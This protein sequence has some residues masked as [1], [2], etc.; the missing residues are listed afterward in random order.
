MRAWAAALLII[1]SGCINPGSVD[2]GVRNL[3]ETRVVD[4]G[5]AQHNRTTEEYYFVI[6]RGSE[7]EE[8]IDG[9]DNA[10][11]VTCGFSPAFDYDENAQS[12]HYDP[13]AVSLPVEEWAVV[14][15]YDYWG[16]QVED[17]SVYSGCPTLHQVHAYDGRASIG[18]HLRPDLPTRIVVEARNGFLAYNET[19]FLPM[20]NKV[21]GNITRIENTQDARYR[22]TGEFEVVNLGAW[23]QSRVSHLE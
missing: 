23:P 21:E 22:I 3:T 5:V 8:V 20:G 16:V 13:G 4:S 18:R 11:R 19:Y 6:V 14:V 9:N 12:L 17:G 15:A 1:A 7:R 2:D 10:A